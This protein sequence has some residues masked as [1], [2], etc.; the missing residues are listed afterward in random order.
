MRVYDVVYGRRF[1]TSSGEEK[2][3]WINCGAIIKTKNGLSL[4]LESIPVEFNG[5]LSLFEPKADDAKGR[6]PY[7]ASGDAD[8][9]IE[10]RIP[11]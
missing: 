3:K 2:T 4:K 10:D 5:W 7:A 11:F 8:P 6:A 1:T 9:N